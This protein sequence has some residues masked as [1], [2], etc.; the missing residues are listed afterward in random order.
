ML[1]A[2]KH[3]YELFDILSIDNIKEL[4][5]DL[6]FHADIDKDDINFGIL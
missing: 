6:K 3:P 5:N 2:Y 1:S 4:N